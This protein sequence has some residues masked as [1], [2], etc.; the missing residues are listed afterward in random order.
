MSDTRWIRAG[1]N[2]ARPLW[3][4]KDGMQVGIWPTSI[5]GGAGDGGPRGLLR[6]GYPIRDAG[7]A[8]GLVNFIAVEPIVGGRR[9]FSELERAARDGKPGR[10]F[11]SGAANHT[12][13]G[14]NAGR[15]GKAG[16]AE[17][18][19]VT[20]YMEKFDNGAQP[21]LELMIRSDR[22]EEVR[23]TTRA[24]PDSAPMDY[25]ILTATMGNYERL[26]RLWL[27]DRIVEAKQIWPGFSG[28]EFTR[29]AFFALDLL[30]RTPE[31]DVLVC[32]TTDE[33]DPGSIPADPQAPWWRWRGSFPVTQYWRKPKGTW[34][35]DLRLRVNGRRLYWACHVPIPGGIAYENFELMERFYEGQTFVFG[36]TRKTP[37]ELGIAAHERR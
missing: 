16:N 2:A 1:I 32:A 14:M 15:L 27:R 22:P 23:L 3:G 17:K 21:V 18:L 6:I 11:W 19:T 34:K 29:D 35:P 8:Q 24:A 5:E 13:E 12:W 4:L 20:I 33:K 31:G 26:R 30:P 7:R 10:I 9:G 28:D 36:V 25:C 37:A